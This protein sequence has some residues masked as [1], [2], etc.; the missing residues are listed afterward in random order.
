MR[1]SASSMVLLL[2]F[3]LVI[4][5]RIFLASAVVARNRM[6]LRK[7]SMD[8]FLSRTSGSQKSAVMSETTVS[9]A[10]YSSK[11]EASLSIMRL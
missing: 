5:I 10:L 3:R 6:P 1:V 4:R 11:A 7:M 8:S 2:A 9:L